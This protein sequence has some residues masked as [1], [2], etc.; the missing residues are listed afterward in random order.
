[1]NKEIEKVYMADFETTTDLD[2]CRVWASCL[3]DI[4][5][6]ECCH[7]SNNIDSFMSYCFTLAR[8][9]VI[10]FHNLKFDGNFIVSWLL[11][12]GYNYDDDPRKPQTFRTIITDTGQWYDI[13]VTYKVTG[14]KRP[15]AYKI[16]FRDSLKKLNFPVRTIAKMFDLPISKGDID[17]KARREVGHELTDEEISYITRDVEIVSLALKNQFEHG[18]VKMTTSSDA[19]SSYKDSL[20]GESEFLKQFP[21]LPMS[22]D[23]LIR[24]AYKGGWTYLKDGYSGKMVGEGCAYDVNSLYP[25]VMYYELLPY[26]YPKE[27]EGEYEYNE[28]YPLFIQFISCEFNIKKDHLP[29]IQLK[30]NARFMETEY[31]KSSGGEVVD[32]VVTSVDL[33]LIKDHYH[34][35]N[36]EYHGGYMFRGKVGMFKKYLDY[37]AEIKENA[38]GGLRTQAKLMMNSLYGKFATNPIRQK[39]VPRL[40]ENEVVKY[41]LH[42]ETEIVDPIYT[43]MACFITAYARD[44]TIRSAQNVYDRFIYADT[45]SIH[46]LGFDVPDIDIHHAR[47]G[48]WKHEGDF[49]KAKFIRAKTYM[50]HYIGHD[51]PEVKCAGMPDKVKKD[52]TFENFHK[53]AVFHGKLV[54]KTVKGGVVLVESDFTIK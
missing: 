53:G 48:A 23:D 6:N 40:D 34:L 19:L 37:W 26:G 51:H 29:C 12:N 10:Y 38:T 54:P 9:S 3:Y 14:K 16:N 43:A 5:T 11:R 7:L 47:L 30:N 13:E 50:E 15:I 39:K 17:Y 25:S 42:E 4:A 24:K 41:S 1:M 33:A 27:F 46:L 35:S 28:M 2:D 49:F 18:H 36:V 20:G 22:Q 8:G 52:V 44:K 31:L 32:L 45:D 21:I